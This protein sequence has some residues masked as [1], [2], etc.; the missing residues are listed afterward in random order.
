MIDPFNF[1]I[2]CFSFV[3]HRGE[4]WRAKTGQHKHPQLLI[5]GRSLQNFIVS[6]GK[7][8]AA[9][10]Q[11]IKLNA[12]VLRLR[13]VGQLWHPTR[14]LGP[15]VWG[16]LPAIGEGVV[17]TPQNIAVFFVCHK[18]RDIEH[19]TNVFG[20]VHIC[21]IK[22]HSPTPL[23]ALIVSTLHYYDPWKMLPKNRLMID[24]NSD[25]A[26]TRVPGQ[27][28]SGTSDIL[29]TVP[30]SPGVINHPSPVTGSQHPHYYDTMGPQTAL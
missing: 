15:V 14:L 9:E 6:A 16:F 23:Y 28:G 27:C 13:C 4:S 30:G 12:V 5:Y 1:W 10:W 18:W 3:C 29:S 19:W 17:L 2:K 7:Q 11:K 8:L 24:L 25:G 20:P 21:Q 26:N 22:A